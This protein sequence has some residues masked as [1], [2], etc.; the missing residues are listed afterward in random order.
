[1]YQTDA[2]RFPDHSESNGQRVSTI[3]LPAFAGTQFR[4]GPYGAISA[5]GSSDGETH[6]VSDPSLAMEDFKTA[7]EFIISNDE[8]I[9]DALFK[10]LVDHYVEMREVELSVLVGEDPDVVLPVIKSSEELLPLCGLVAVHVN[11]IAENGEPIFGI[12]LGCNWDSDQAAGARFAGVV[13]E[14]AGEANYAFVF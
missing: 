12:E 7:V 5:P 8:E 2:P 3:V 4:N 1:M 10:S 14:A 11:K 9:R 6:A 13:V